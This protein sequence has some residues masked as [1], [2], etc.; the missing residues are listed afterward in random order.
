MKKIICIS[1]AFIAVCAFAGGGGLPAM[2]EGGITHVVDTCDVGAYSNQ[3][4]VDVFNQIEGTGCYVT[5]YWGIYAYY[6]KIETSGLAAAT[7]YAQFYFFVNDINTLTRVFV[8]FGGG[9]IAERD[10]Y[11]WDLQTYPI[12]QGWNFITLKFSEALVTGT[13]DFHELVRLRM[14]FW[15]DGANY[16]KV[17][18]ITLTDTPATVE[19]SVLEAAN[20]DKRINAVPLT[21][22][23][24]AAEGGIG[25]FGVLGF[26][27]GGAAIAASVALVAVCLLKRRK[28]V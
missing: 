28:A 17:D 15:K 21:N 1:F 19:R 16:I 12:E 10:E 22:I 14:V 2:A 18:C 7:A 5:N 27:F 8:Y 20:V 6:P 3:L 26:V 4:D 9:V 23:P 25:A 13:P 24:P 11:G